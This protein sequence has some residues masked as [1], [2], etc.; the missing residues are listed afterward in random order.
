MSSAVL[1]ERSRPATITLHDVASEAG[2]SV[3]TASRAIRGD[4]VGAATRARVLATA[5]RLGYAPNRLAQSLRAQQSMFVGVIVPDIGHGLF[6]RTVAA[7]QDVF[8]RAGYQVLLMNTR[9]SPEQ[10]GV[11]LRAMLSTNVDGLVFASYG[12]ITASPPVPTIFFDTV[13]PGAGDA[14]VAFSN[15]EGIELLVGHL[16]DRS[17]AHGYNRIAY[18]GSP[19]P[20]T[21]A[22]ERIEGFL[23]AMRARAL[24]VRDD[25]MVMGDEL[26]SPE[27]GTAA[28]NRLL[29]LDEPP[30][31]VVA[32]SDTFA[33][34]AIQAI[35][36]AGLRVPEDVAIVS[37]DDTYFGGFMEPQLTALK[38]I[39]GTVGRTI[40]S[41]LL[42]TFE[43]GRS[44]ESLQIR[45]PAELIVRHS[46]GC[47]G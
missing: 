27:S 11:A 19:L 29:A 2:V 39:H 1:Q 15:R 9:R 30:H 22:V 47:H 28:M 3:A 21:S 14:N 7:A 42:Q 44:G 16:A 38:A 40:A 5:K 26:W 32:A 6:A 41:L 43:H 17:G 46:C 25:Y 34:G 18:I 8:D 23:E 31:A 33:L 45:V 13:V 36:Q 20:L 10:D 24:P 12:G 35:V 4:A 37:F